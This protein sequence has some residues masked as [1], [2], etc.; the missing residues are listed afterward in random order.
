MEKINDIL[1]KAPI[2]LTTN[3]IILAAVAIIAIYVLIKAISGIIKTVAILGVC[4][5]VLM[6][7]QSTNLVNIPV[8][9]DT[10]TTIEKLIPS[11]EVWTEAV[12]KADKIS[13]AVNELK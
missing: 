4:Y 5:F 13:K 9:K 6:S 3:T 2:H 1:D 7:L 8:I 12:D 11:K 10:Y